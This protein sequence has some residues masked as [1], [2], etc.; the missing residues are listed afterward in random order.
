[1]STDNNTGIQTRAMAQCV[2]NEAD[3]EQSQGLPNPGMNPTVE[4]HKTKDEAIKEF[5]RKN[6]TIALDWYVPDFCNTRVGDLIEQRLPLET[7]EGKILFSCPTLSEFFKTSNFE[8]DLKTGRV[9]TYLDPPEDIGVSCKK[10]EFDLEFLRSILQDEHDTR[11]VKEEKL[12]RI[13]RIKRVAGPADVMDREEAEYKVLQFCQLWTLYADNSV[14]LKR[15][16]ELSQESTVAACKVYV[17]YISDIIRQ[18]DEVMKIFAIE[19]EFRLIKNRGHFPVPQITPQDSKIKTARDKDKTLE[20]VDKM[21]AAMLKAIT[22]SEEAYIREQDQARARDEQ[23]R[24]ARQ[25]DRSGFNY[26]SLANSTPIRNDNTRSDAPGVHFNTN[27][28][29]HVYSTTSDSN[30]QYE[31]PVNDSIIQTAASAPTDQL[32]TNTTGATGC[33]D[34]WRCNNSTGTATGT[35][36]HRPST[37]PTSRN[38]LHN[39]TSPNSSDNR[40][41]PICFRCGEQGHMR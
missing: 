41:S 39:N 24:S 17:P 8:L 16:S 29:R 1:M 6:G 38:G 21:A 27:P 7:T 33:N 2:E 40:N 31:P 3:T 26:F 22:Q 35:A 11:T 34:L 28:T 20:T 32:T 5:V 30:D 37:G 12:E 25:T 4:L 13:P 14:E 10:E 36:T 23:L 15:K 9:Y 18:L 19:K